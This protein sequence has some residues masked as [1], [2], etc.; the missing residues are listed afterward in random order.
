MAE[1]ASLVVD[2]EPLT[3][4]FDGRARS[5]EVADAAARGVVA[6]FA[7]GGPNAADDAIVAMVAAHKGAAGYRVVTSDAELRR[8]L[9]AAGATV[10]GVS[11]FLR[12]LR[13]PGSVG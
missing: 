2:G 8:R 6:E 13:P 1:L 7:P 10:V 12:L 3:V 4:V 5:G 9:E 11:A